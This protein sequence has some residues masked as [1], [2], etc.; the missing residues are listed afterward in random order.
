MITSV[1]SEEGQPIEVGPGRGDLRYGSTPFVWNLP[2]VVR[3]VDRQLSFARL[4]T[5]QP[6]IGACVGWMMRQSLRVPLKLYKRTGEDSRERLRPGEH[7]LA[8]ALATPWEGASVKNLIDALLGPLLVHGNGLVG[9]EQG[10]KNAIQF[11]PYDWRWVLPIMPWP[12]TIAGWEINRQWPDRRADVPVDSVLHAAYW[13]PLGPLG[14]SPLQQLGITIAIE[15]AAQRHQRA[16]LSNGARPPS[17]I[18]AAA[19]FLG[20][21]ADERKE[22]L[23]NL[24][25]DIKDIYAGPENSGRPA[26]L[27]P[28]LEWKQVGHTAIEAAL[29]DQRHVAR[30][31]A[32]GVYGMTPACLGIIERGAELPEQRQI[33]ITDG[34][35]PPLMLIEDVIN[36][37]L[38]MARL[39]EEDVF[40]EFDFAG[41]LRGDRLAEI[42][43]I[44]EAVATAVLTP[45]EGRSVLNLPQSP[46][47]QMDEFYLPFNNLWP[48]SQEPPK[49]G[50]RELEQAT[51]EEEGAT[52][53][54]GTEPVEPAKEPTP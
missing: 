32:L 4:F 29:I 30:Q 20:L 13:G 2:R 43:A 21:R 5:E 7:V 52:P 3:L 49:S 50:K 51:G 31:E 1:V 28:G 27:P 35:A 8:D 41:I 26:L 46:L 10:A 42:E 16:M 9:F 44:R 53:K 12:D 37:Q 40:C 18:Q 47:P 36:S 6:L 22:L 15:D 33:A 17:A 54:G 11:E 45:N 24:R 19:E 39:G 23:E 14:V 34:L 25:T 48:I 38:I